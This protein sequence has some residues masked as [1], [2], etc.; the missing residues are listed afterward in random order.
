MRLPHLGEQQPQVVVNLGDR[1]QRAPRIGRPG[2]LVDRH[3]RRQP[4]DRVNVGP[5]KLVEELPGIARKALEIPALAFGINRVKS[6]RALS[7]AA[8]TGQDHQAVARQV[9]VDILQVVHAGAADLD[10]RRVGAGR[11][12]M[13]RLGLLMA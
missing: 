12:L 6:Q 7:R 11:G 10:R 3:G 5:L 13:H 8:H 9:D 4:L 2:P 1:P